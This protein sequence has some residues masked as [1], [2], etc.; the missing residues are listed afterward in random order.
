MLESRVKTLQ[1]FGIKIVKRDAF[2]RFLTGKNVSA[3]KKT[4]KKTETRVLTEER[5]KEFYANGILEINIPKGSIITALARDFAKEKKNM[6]IAIN[7]GD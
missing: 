3:V 5:M 4:D 7:T 1:S 6:V 2:L